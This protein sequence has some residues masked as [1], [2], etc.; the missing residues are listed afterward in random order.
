ME[1]MWSANSAESP[2]LFFAIATGALS[3]PYRGFFCGKLYAEAS[4]VEEVGFSIY[5]NL[6]NVSQTNRSCN[7]K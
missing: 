7:E 3:L 1:F 5:H 2:L 6:R 4:T